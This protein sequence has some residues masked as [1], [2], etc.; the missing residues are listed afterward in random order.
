[1]TA[2]QANNKSAVLGPRYSCLL[3]SLHHRLQTYNSDVTSASYSCHSVHWRARLNCPSARDKTRLL[4]ISPLFSA[5]TFH[6][7]SLQDGARVFRL[8]VSLHLSVSLWN[9][10]LIFIHFYY[11]WY[12]SAWITIVLYIWEYPDIVLDGSWKFPQ[13]FVTS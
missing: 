11:K 10:C 2:L 5:R 1:M 7:L 9:R 8:R 13:Q 6:L 4:Y 3:C 12:Y